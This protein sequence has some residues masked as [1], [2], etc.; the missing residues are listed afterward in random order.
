MKTPFRL[1]ALALAA[2]LAAGAAQA[3]FSERNFKLSSGSGKDHP[4]GDGIVKM[5]AC[6]QAKSGGRMK[7]TPYFD[8]QLGNDNTATQSVRSGQIDMVLPST[9]PLVPIV[10]ELGVLDLPF[11]FDSEAEADAVLDGK[12]GQWLAAKLPAAGLVNLAYWENGFRNA[13]NNKRPI[14]RIEDFGGLKMRVM[15]N[16]V[17][18]DTFKELGANAVP[19]AFSEVYSALETKT[20]DGQENPF[21]LIDNMK[22]YEVQKYL[23]LTRHSYAALAMLMSKKVWDGLSAPEQE[24]LK[25]CAAEGRDEERKVSRAKAGQILEGLK[26]KGMTINEIP[27]AEMQRIREKVKVVWDRQAKTIGTEAMD[28]VMGELKRV[29][30]GK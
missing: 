28:L 24:A 3:Q 25:A 15:Q 13:T 5:N 12:A 11:L 7:I 27:P 20:V 21:A 22:F 6:L 10:P 9:A 14:A 4:T 8:N 16:P 29:R 18:I 26:G 23:S 30:G 2:T 1:A 19:M 17:Y